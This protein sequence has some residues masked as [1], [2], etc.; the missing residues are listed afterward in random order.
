[1]FGLKARSYFY[2]ENQIPF[3]SEVSGFRL[4]ISSKRSL[5][6]THDIILINKI[7]RAKERLVPQHRGGTILREATTQKP[8]RIEN[9]EE[10]K[11]E[12]GG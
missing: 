10:D 6:M 8:G 5:R 11:L 3:G 2:V 12:A 9:L 7:K 4:K 1:M